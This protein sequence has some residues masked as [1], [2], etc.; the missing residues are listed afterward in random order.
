MSFLPCTHLWLQP[1][2]SI[3]SVQ[4]IG[5]S[6]LL[7]GCCLLSKA[8]MSSHFHL[9]FASRPGFFLE[10]DYFILLGHGRGRSKGWEQLASNSTT[11]W[12]LNQ[13][14]SFSSLHA[15]FQTLLTLFCPPRVPF[16][17]F[18]ALQIPFPGRQHGGEERI[19]SLESKTMNSRCS[20]PTWHLSVLGRSA[21]QLF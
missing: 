14:L 17:L 20:F 18:S 5:P 6:G 3:S 10:R 19:Q 16:L 11:T 12:I 13:L 9:G 21:P 15:H 1:P 8:W 2:T 7:H 4:S